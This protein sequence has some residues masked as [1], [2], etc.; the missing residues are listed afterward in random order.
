VAQITI[1]NRDRMRESIL[2]MQTVRLFNEVGFVRFIPQLRRP[3]TV[4]IVG[5]GP[6][7]PL[8]A[9]EIDAHDLVVRFNG[10]RNYGMSGHRTDYL[11]L[12]NTGEPA[13]QFAYD[14]LAL[15]AHAVEA[16]GRILLARPP[17]LVASELR[18][19]PDDRE[20]WET[21]DP[22]L[23]GRIR[24][25]RWA[26]MRANIYRRARAVLRLYGAKKSD[27]PST[28]ILAIFHI[29]Q[30]LRRQMRHSSITL[31]GF[32][33]QGWDRHPWNAERQLI[34]ERWRGWVRRA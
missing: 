26:Y 11:V 16:A 21:F 1:S 7:D 23:I 12:T 28:G 20:Y 33:H 24:H 32:T 14:P 3:M 17:N 2:N 30:Q 5:N 22:D 8:H 9:D 18:R 15:N 10:C 4:A 25:K 27:Q 13:R 6:I 34:D 19:F 29:A 31:Y